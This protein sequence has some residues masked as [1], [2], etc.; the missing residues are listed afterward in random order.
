MRVTDHYPWGPPKAF[1]NGRWF[2]VGEIRRF[3]RVSQPAVLRAVS[4]LGIELGPLHFERLK[5]RKGQRFRL[6]TREEA[7]RVIEAVR[8]EQG[9]R[10]LGERI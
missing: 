6:L 1:R 5:R 7:T 3:L 10:A 8:A 2:S 4:A 9:M